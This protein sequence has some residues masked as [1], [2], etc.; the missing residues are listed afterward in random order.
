MFSFIIHDSTTDTY[1]VV[2]DHIGITPLY[3]GW[4]IDGSCWLASEMKA[5]VK[6]CNVLKQFPPGHLYVKRPSEEGAFTRWYTPKY[7]AEVTP[8]GGELP[9]DTYDAKALREAFEKAVVR[10]MMSDVPWGVLLSGGLD[11]R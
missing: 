9:K 2:R 8:I 11:S 5:M 4:G 1:V 10:R 6:S 3:I 7:V